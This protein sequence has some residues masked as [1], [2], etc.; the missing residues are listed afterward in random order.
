[1]AVSAAPP[2]A[3]ASVPPQNDEAEVAV[4]GTV[5]LTEQ[6]LDQILVDLKLS[7][8]DFYRPRHQLIFRSMLRLKEKAEPEA[9]DAITVC[10][11]LARQRQLEEA[12]GTAYV[13]ALPTMV[14]AAGAVRDYARIVGEHAML[15]RLLGAVREIQEEV[16]T[17]GGDPRAL[18]ER[19]EQ[20]I[21]R[22]GH[23]DESSQLRSIEEVLHEELDKLERLSKEGQ[24]LTGTPSGFKDLDEI[25]GGFQP[26]NLIVL[27]ARPAMGKCLTG[28]A[29]IYDPT[30]G[31]RRPMREVV[32]AIERGHD[33]WVASL[34]SD[35]K[36]RTAKA[37]GALRNGRR[38]IFRITTKLGRRIEATSN[39]PL[40]TVSGW[41]QVMELRPGSRIGVPR[42]LPRTGVVRQMPDHE[43]VLLAALIADGSLTTAT[44]R[45]CFGTNS[46]VLPEVERAVSA[47]GCQLRLGATSHGTACITAGRGSGPNPVRQL[48]LDHDLW[49]RRSRDKF[50][51]GAIL[52]LDDAQIARFL[53]V[54]YGCDGHIHATERLRQI[55]YS[56]ISE[57]LAHD[58]QH[59]L[60][61]LGIVSV[62]RR[63]RRKVYEGTET[64]AREVRITG[65]E[66]LRQ[67]CHVVGAVGKHEAVKRLLVGLGKASVHTNTDTLPVEVWEEVLAAKGQRPWNEVSAVAGRPSSHNWHVSSRGLSRQLTGQLAVAIGD[68]GLARLAGSDLWWDEVA[69]IES[70]GEEETYDIEVPE[71]HNFVA[72]DLVV[73]NSA[74]A[75][76]IAENAA[77]DHGK[78]V[79]L[80]SLEMSESELAQRFIASRGKIGGESLRKGRVKPEQWP[81]VLRATEKLTKAPL[82]VDDSS[83]IGVLEL[84]AKA[85]RLNQR[86]PLGLLIVDYLQLMR[87]EDPR[88]GR[89]EQ[90]GK[91]SRGLKILA[92]ELS[93]PVI[94]ISQLS[95]AVEARPDKRPLMSDLRESGNLEQDADLVMFVFREDYYDKESERQGI[96]DIIIGKHRNGP[97]G[98]VEL[99]FLDRYP[100]FMSKAPDRVAVATGIA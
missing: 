14:P 66:S 92:R 99:T 69:T 72:D 49:G 94:A 34:D 62:I 75:T 77:V 96:A 30:T 63:L 7:P 91:I 86:H 74:L 8:E 43:L 36:L 4:L 2:P 18:V 1:V 60:L 55:G 54:L 64:A 50:V 17:E 46:P 61:R 93:I 31:A 71:Y 52:A 5:L 23:H 79:A 90:V 73:H 3:A 59:L 97:V 28:S 33:A 88:D 40:L 65:Q 19:A 32:P 41:Q 25:T 13:H 6:A 67:F 16:A 37:T 44:P 100:K 38:E 81:T 21:F 10:D 70:I 27:A 9:V 82:F 80:F 78:A 68:P 24:S 15:R 76:N 56:T 48:C 84:R 29:L 53:A 26:G 42:S 83:D 20:K 87:V 58:V 12:G 11:D 47:F 35:L 98:S 57:R 39:H 95:R 89:V 85:R 51:P 22:A 45:F